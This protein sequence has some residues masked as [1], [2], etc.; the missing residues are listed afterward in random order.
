M[1]FILSLLKL[2]KGAEYMKGDIIDSNSKVLYT[3]LF[4]LLSHSGK[5]ITDLKTLDR[6]KNAILELS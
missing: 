2:P 6:H 4:S 1:T 3:D 5:L